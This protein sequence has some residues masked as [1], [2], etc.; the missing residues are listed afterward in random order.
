[1]TFCKSKGKIFKKLHDYEKWNFSPLFVAEY[2]VGDDLV[3]TAWL[4]YNKSYIIGRVKEQS[5]TCT[6]KQFQIYIN[7]H[8]RMSI[9]NIHETS[10]ASVD[11]QILAFQN[12]I[13]KSDD[14]LLEF[15]C[16]CKI[17]IKATEPDKHVNFILPDINPK[18]FQ[19]IESYLNYRNNNL[20]TLHKLRKYMTPTA[21]NCNVSIR[22]KINVVE[23]SEEYRLAVGTIKI[24]ESY[25]AINNHFED[26]GEGVGEL[27]SSDIIRLKMYDTHTWASSIIRD[28]SQYICNNNNYKR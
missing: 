8:G 6:R 26:V 9:T 1:M 17:R 20:D 14:V 7:Q 2:Y 25:R 15:G 22:E 13:E 18:I 10:P 27:Y 4:L 16:S 28:I 24:D 3:H 21:A 23:I 12:T 19:N 11:G 5:L